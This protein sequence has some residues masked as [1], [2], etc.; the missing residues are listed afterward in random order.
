MGEMMQ[1]CVVKKRDSWGRGGE[2]DEKEM[3]P[4]ENCI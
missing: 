1:E 2:G 4:R 3:N